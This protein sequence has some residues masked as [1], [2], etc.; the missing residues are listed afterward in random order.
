[1][2]YF[3]DRILG[4]KASDCNMLIDSDPEYLS[5]IRACMNDI[6]TFKEKILNHPDCRSWFTEKEIDDV[7]KCSKQAEHN[8]MTGVSR[9][10]EW[11]FMY[12]TWAYLY[13]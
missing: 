9:S 2:D 10:R 11:L 6:P 5:S 8:F 12:N 7:V 13:H 4:H 3:I 1:M